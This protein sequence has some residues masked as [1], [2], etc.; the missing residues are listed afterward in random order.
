M[1][2]LRRLVIA[3]IV[4]TVVFWCIPLLLFPSGWF[5]ALGMP[6]PQPLVFVRLLGATY[7]ALAVGYYMGLKGLQV[8]ESPDPVINMGIA[9]NGLAFLTLAYFG[10]NGSWLTWGLVAQG[11]MWLSA[12][13]TLAMTLG[14]LWARRCLAVSFDKGG[15]TP[16]PLRKVHRKGGQEWNKN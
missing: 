13:A 15:V 3:K 11:Y 2:G 16:E 14:L 12:L 7:F 8:G 10:A 4:I 6:Y 1:A 5:V 9:S